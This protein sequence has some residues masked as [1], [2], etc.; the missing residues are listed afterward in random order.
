[1]RA[2][3]A[4]SR[5][6]GRVYIEMSPSRQSERSAAATTASSTSYRPP[7]VR[8]KEERTVPGGKVGKPWPDE[9]WEGG[10]ARL[11]L[12]SGSDG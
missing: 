2:R 8:V 5:S 7:W 10:L 11:R 4:I 6:D 3:A 1:M 9:G 12:F